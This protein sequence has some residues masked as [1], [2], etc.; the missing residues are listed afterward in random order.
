MNLYITVGYSED[1]KAKVIAG[2]EQSYAEQKEMLRTMDG[3]GYGRVEL[4]SRSSGKIKQRRLKVKAE[5]KTAKIKAN[6][7]KDSNENQ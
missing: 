4:W 1:G 5:K 3:K 2:P 6:K 7:D